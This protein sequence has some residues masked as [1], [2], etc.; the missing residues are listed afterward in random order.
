MET[1]ASFEARSAPSSYPTARRG[2]GVERHL[3]NG[4]SRLLVRVPTRAKP[5]SSAGCPVHGTADEKSELGARPGHS[6][7][8]RCARLSPALPAG[9]TPAP[10]REEPPHRE[11]SLGLMEA[12][13]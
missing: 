10:E 1:A 12:T 9:E 4:F 5:A 2:R 3:R 6:G 11:S 13:T 7:I 8:F